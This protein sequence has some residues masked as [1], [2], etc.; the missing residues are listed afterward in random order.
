MDGSE[1]PWCAVEV[2]SSGRLVDGR[3]GKCD[4]ATC[5]DIASG[6]EQAAREEPRSLTLTFSN[7]SG[8]FAIKLVFFPLS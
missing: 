3:W 7:L 5:P 8:K 6:Q 1:F 4:M 2:D